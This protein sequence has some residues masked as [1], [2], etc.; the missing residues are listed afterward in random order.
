M[1]INYDELENWT[2]TRK[3]FLE[4]IN[5]HEKLDQSILLIKNIT[6]EPIPANMRRLNSFSAAGIFPK[7]LEDRYSGS[8]KG[9]ELKFTKEHYYRYSLT[10]RLRKEGYKL[11]NIAKMI[12]SLT[13]EEVKS[14]V[15]N[16]NKDDFENTIINDL[17]KKSISLS[18]SL[19]KLGRVDGRVLQSEQIRL[20]VTPWFHTYINKKDLDK[21]NDKDI[22]I[23]TNALA[24]K[25][26]NYKARRK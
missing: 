3:Q 8:R 5:K 24:Q 6:K 4:L 18:E 2:G 9:W 10:M 17:K 16:W 20:A 19:K 23:L 12:A 1:A 13:I 15:R 21:I 26:K 22:D 25:L 7:E 11:E 14:K